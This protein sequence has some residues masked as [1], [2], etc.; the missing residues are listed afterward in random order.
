[1]IGN[2]SVNAS[3]NSTSFSGTVNNAINAV[4]A[5]NAL[6]LGGIAAANYANTSNATITQLHANVA[7][8]NNI[9]TVA[10]FVGNS[11]VNAS[12][13]STAFS[14]TANNTL[15]VGTVAAANIANTS[16]PVFSDSI[17]VGANVV[18]NTSTITVGTASINSTQIVIAN[19]V[20]NIIVANGS[21]GL[22]GQAL[23]SAGP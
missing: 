5:N 8:L 11:T 12:I 1:T 20:P 21:V 6:N 4:T 23:L 18:V 22:T 19:V 10:I 17:A 2:S 13:N 3:I 9:S 7:T 15:F 16:A 14:G